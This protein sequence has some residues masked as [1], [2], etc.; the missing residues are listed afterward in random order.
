MWFRLVPWDN[1]EEQNILMFKLYSYII[2]H[3]SLTYA[4]HHLGSA[5]ESQEQ[6]P[7]QEVQEIPELNE[8]HQNLDTNLPECP[9]HQPST[10]TQGKPRSILSLPAL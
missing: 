3:L 2:L 4:L 6:H 5:E 8:E 7:E 1:F 10:F 9:D